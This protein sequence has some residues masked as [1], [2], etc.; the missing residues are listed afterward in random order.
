MTAGQPCLLACRHAAQLL[1]VSSM[2]LSRQVDT[3]ALLS[4]RIL[5]LVLRCIVS[6]QGLRDM[7][8]QAQTCLLRQLPVGPG[9]C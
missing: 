4:G 9:G 7:M 1:L 5:L 6:A 3:S 8:R 2:R